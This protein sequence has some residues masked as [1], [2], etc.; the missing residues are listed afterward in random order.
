MFLLCVLLEPLITHNLETQNQRRQH[1]ER[2]QGILFDPLESPPLT[3]GAQKLYL[4]LEQSFAQ[5]DCY[6]KP[7]AGSQS[8]LFDRWRLVGIMLSQNNP[9]T[10]IDIFC[11]LFLCRTPVP[12]PCQPRIRSFRLHT[13][14][15]I[16]GP[17]IA[18]NTICS[19]RTLFVRWSCINV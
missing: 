5:C 16:K 3:P 14:H 19:R 12:R 1:S 9:E 10:D 18:Q 17:S 6:S 7:F 15:V 11:S 13:L 8:S 2:T 4:H